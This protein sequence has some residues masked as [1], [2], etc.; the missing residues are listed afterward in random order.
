MDTRQE[1]R[2]FIATKN[3]ANVNKFVGVFT[4]K[5]LLFQALEELGINGCNIHGL[6]RN[7]PF[8]YNALVKALESKKCSVYGSDG[9]LVYLISE[10]PVNEINRELRNEEGRD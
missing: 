8:S 2:V 5:K 1:K 6:R 4:N 10:V 9:V 7:I 3:I